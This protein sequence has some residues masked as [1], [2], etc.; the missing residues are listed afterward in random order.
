MTDQ[1]F[2]KINSLSEEA[3]NAAIQKANELKFDLN[4]GGIPLIESFSNLNLARAT[5]KDADEEVKKL[6]D[7]LITPSKRM[8]G[9]IW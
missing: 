4:K 3:Q 1:I 2:E 6:I 9:P 5:L 8:V 7:Q